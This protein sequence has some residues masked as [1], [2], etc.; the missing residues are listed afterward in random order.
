MSIGRFN[1][2]WLLDDQRASVYEILGYTQEL[3]EEN[4]VLQ[5]RIDNL[6]RTNDTYQQKPK[7]TDNASETPVVP[8]AG[9]GLV[10]LLVIVWIFRASIWTGVTTIVRW[11]LTGLLVFASTALLLALVGFVV[12]LIMKV[13]R[14]IKNRPSKGSRKERRI[15]KT[16][17]SVK[18]SSQ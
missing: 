18:T 12:W 4:E 1:S 11:G 13:V 15:K 7:T 6:V 16:L 5:V 2:R 9:I 8:L 17:D 10:L 14:A 3:E